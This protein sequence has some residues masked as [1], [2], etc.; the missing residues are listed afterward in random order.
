MSAYG[1]FERSQ[2]HYKGSEYEEA[3]G[4]ISK[5]FIIFR[6]RR[7]WEHFGG[8]RR[9]SAAFQRSKEL[10]GDLRKHCRELRRVS[11]SFQRSF[12]GGFLGIFR[13]FKESLIRY[14]EYEE[15]SGD[16]WR[17]FRKF[18]RISMVFRGVTVVYSFEEIFE[19]IKECSRDPGSRF[20]GRCNDFKRVPRTF[21]ATKTLFNFCE[22]PLNLL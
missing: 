10:A 7:H 16:F 17:Y 20:Q 9:I 6:R 2:I 18:H 19:E 8:F 21:Q 14:R 13:G 4:A 11:S 5:I 3:F 12:T 22:S 1:G 15:A